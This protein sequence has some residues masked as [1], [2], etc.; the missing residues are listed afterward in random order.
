MG[1]F[2]IKRLKKICI[3]EICPLNFDY[4][5]RNRH[6]Q[7]NHNILT[8]QFLFS[9][10]T[11]LTTN[12]KTDLKTDLKIDLKTDLSMNLKT[13]LNTD[14]KTNLKTDFKTDVKIYH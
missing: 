6:E 7:K 11:D 5:R 4:D 14:L 10:K 12:L 9:V 1:I 3:L 2:Y 8:Q 13:E